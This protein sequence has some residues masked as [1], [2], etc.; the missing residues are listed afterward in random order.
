MKRLLENNRILSHKRKSFDK[1]LRFIR[2]IMKRIWVLL[3]LVVFGPTLTVRAQDFEDT[4]NAFASRNQQSFDRFADS[5]NR[6]FAEAMIANMKMFTGEKPRVQDPKPK[7]KMLPEIKKNK[8][9]EIPSIKPHLEQSTQP[10]SAVQV[11][12]SSEKHA[13]SPSEQFD[14]LDF[15]LFGENVHLGRKSFPGKLTGISAEDVSSFWVKLSECDYEPMLQTCRE[16]HTKRGFND[17]AVYQLVL[18]FASQ[19]YPQQYNEQA[20]MAVFLLN[21]LGIEAKIGFGGAHLFCLLAVEQQLFGVSFVDIKGERYYIFELDPVFLNRDDTISFRTYDI[22]FLKPTKELDMNIMQPLI[23]SESYSLIDSAI[24]IST[25]MI[26]LFG[27]YPQVDIAVY[28]NARPSSVFSESVEQFFQPYLKSLSPIEA[29]SFLLSYVQYGFDYA[30]DE[31]QFGYEKPFFCEENFYYPQN[32][33]E[34]RC[35]LFAFLVR[36]LLNLDVVF[37]DYPGHIATAVHFP[38][39]VNGAFVEHNGKRYVICDPTYVGA[40]VGMEMP[41]FTPKDRG[42]ILLNHY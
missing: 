29:V 24:T 30:A 39:R 5:I 4:F 3:A 1:G 23:S 42:L 17:W 8:T 9:P 33:C 26:E 25:S 12:P 32:D 2:V 36:H 21:Q 16:A 19:T 31:Q 34:D 35:V 10:K 7:P 11:Q 13:D 6:Q 28:A 27:T 15:K 40:S 37:V 22:P 14:E 18:E 20:V 38:M 41:P